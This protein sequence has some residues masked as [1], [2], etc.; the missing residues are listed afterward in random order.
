MYL[1]HLNY[2][3]TPPC[4]TITM[5]IT[6]FIIVLVLKSYENMEIWHFKLSQLANNSKPCENS[7]FEDMFKVSVPSFHT[8]SK[9]QNDLVD[10]VLW[11]IISLFARLSSTVDGIWLGLKC[12]VT[13]KHSSP[14]MLIKRIKVRWV[15]WPFSVSDE[16]TAV[17]GNPVLSQLRR[18]SRC[19][20]QL[21]VLL[22]VFCRDR[23]ISQSLLTQCLDSH[24][25]IHRNYPWLQ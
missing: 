11:Q 13:F 24:F 12:L 6:I 10:G 8:S 5:K 22:W 7:L 20:V 25:M 19:S 23:A 3:T 1:L 14:D 21:R 4:K 15:R 16:V 18:V 17:G 9:T 2:I